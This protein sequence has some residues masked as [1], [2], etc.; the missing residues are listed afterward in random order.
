MARSKTPK[1]K[2]K[3]GKPSLRIR[4]LEV[5]SALER[6][7]PDAECALHFRNPFELLVATI[8]S[9]QCTDTMVNRVTPILFLRYPGTNALAG[10]AL[11]DVEEII[12][13][14]GFFRAKAKNLVAMSKALEEKHDGVVPENLEAL[15]GLPGVGRKTANVVLGTAFGIASG[16]VVDTHVKR[17]VYRLGL[18]RQKD[19]VK[20]EQELMKLLPAEHWVMFSHRLIWHGRKVCVAARPRCSECSLEPLCPKQGVRETR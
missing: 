10:A 15:T 20:I 7:Y 18:T 19:P 9:A 12:H 1:S 16:V 5:A 4:A 13:S 14:T 2:A 17:L 3:P 8:L 6:A 11:G